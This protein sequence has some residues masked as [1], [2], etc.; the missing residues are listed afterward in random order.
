MLWKCATT[1]PSFAERE[2]RHLVLGVHPMLMVDTDASVVERLLLA[3]QLACP[4]CGAVLRPGGHGGT[5][6]CYDV[7]MSYAQ[8]G[9]PR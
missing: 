7:N 9:G 5:P 1:L 8:E 6:T 4:L 3:G 2:G